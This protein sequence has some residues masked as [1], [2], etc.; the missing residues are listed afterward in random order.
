MKE[1]KLQVHFGPSHYHLRAGC[2]TAKNPEFQASSDL[3]IT[4]NDKSSFK[5]AQQLLIHK[6]FNLETTCRC[7]SDYL[8]VALRE[9]CVNQK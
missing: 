2:I 5:E 3:L 4:E 1:G 8:N 9:V 6:E 7:S